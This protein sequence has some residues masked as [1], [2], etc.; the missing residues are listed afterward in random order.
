MNKKQI[1]KIVL[2][3]IW[4]GVIFMLSSEP[5]A[6]S[7]TRSG[8][9]VDTIK[10]INPSVADTENITFLVRKAAHITAYFILG[11]LMLRVVRMYSRLPKKAIILSIVFVAVYAISDELHQLLVNGR[12]GEVRDVFIDTSAGTLGVFVTYMNVRWHAQRTGV[13]TSKNAENKV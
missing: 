4:L 12:S 11:I 1:L 5:S 10:N 7:S 3:V 13:G 6:V 2:L 9:I 8:A